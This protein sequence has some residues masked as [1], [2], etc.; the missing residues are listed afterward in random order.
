MRESCETGPSRVFSTIESLKDITQRSSGSIKRVDC[1]DIPE[2]R[3]IK[4]EHVKIVS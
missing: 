2:L 3:D 4:F 1:R